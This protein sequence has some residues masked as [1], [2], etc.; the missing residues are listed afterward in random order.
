MTRPRVRRSSRGFGLLVVFVAFVAFLAFFTFLAL[1]LFAL[2]ILPVSA[3]FLARAGGL[4][5]LAMV[6]ELLR[7]RLAPQL[8][9]QARDGPHDVLGGRGERRGVERPSGVLG[10]VDRWAG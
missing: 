10:Q 7:R 9:E 6:I 1:V 3:G 4:Y 8:A 2:S 5:R